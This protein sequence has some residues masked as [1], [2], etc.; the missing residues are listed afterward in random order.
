MCK[1]LNARSVRN[2]PIR[3]KDCY[4]IIFFR[5]VYWGEEGCVCI[6]FDRIF[7][8]RVRNICSTFK[9]R[10]QCSRIK[11]YWCLLRHFV[12]ISCAFDSQYYWPRY[13]CNAIL[14]K[15]K[16]NKGLS[17]LIQYE[18]LKYASICLRVTHQCVRL[19]LNMYKS[20][21]TQWIKSVWLRVALKTKLHFFKYLFKAIFTSIEIESKYL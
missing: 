17:G 8:L 21:W 1:Y 7:V 3:W 9:G 5:N 20:C 12:K 13:P 16:S 10:G 4:K 6:T 15:T 2:G 19:M 14:S 18:Y 11:I